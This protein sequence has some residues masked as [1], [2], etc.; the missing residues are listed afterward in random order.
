MSDFE[1]RVPGKWVLTGEH[2]VLRGGTAI[3][4][5][6]PEARLTLRC[7]PAPEL[8]IA[9][10]EADR[11]IRELLG[12]LRDDWEASDRV[13]PWPKGELELE[14]TIPVGAGLG[15]SAALC[16][17]MT[18]WLADSL[19]VSPSGFLEFAKTLEH[20]FHGRSSGMDVAVVLAGEP[21][22][23]SIEKG[24]Q[25]LG[26]RKLPRFTFHDTGLRARTNECILRVEA[27]RERDLTRAMRLDEAMSNASRNA[28]EGLFLYDGR[29]RADGLL[30]I[31]QAMDQASECFYSWEIVPGEAKR[32]QEDLRRQGALASK[33]TGAG[34]GGM[35]V[36]LWPDERL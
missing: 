24:P 15:S 1:T 6:H 19:D 13:F 25:P 12:A 20:R 35:I 2:S 3:A 30:R 29:S 31:A 8:R 11:E 22:S 26:I 23:Y 34:G 36:A 33:L 14:S 4:L 5:P 21:I 28:V 32:I 7:K 17:A 27:I 18:R 10:P 9:P 16:V